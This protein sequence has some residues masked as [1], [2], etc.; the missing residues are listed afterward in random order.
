MGEVV[1]QIRFEQACS[2]EDILLRRTRM[3]FLDQSSMFEVYERL[4][5][6]FAEEMSWDAKRTLEY[7]KANFQHIRKLEF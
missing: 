4:V 5:K 3:G 2:P 6:I 7:A 1:Y